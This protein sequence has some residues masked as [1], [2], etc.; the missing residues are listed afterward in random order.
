MSGGRERA[1][2]LADAFESVLGA[3][4]LDQG[5]EAARVFLLG[6]RKA[7]LVLSVRT[8]FAVIL[9]QGCRK[10]RSRMAMLISSTS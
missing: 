10:L 6:L 1:S 2:I 3:Y 8:A 5:M 4:Y 9:K 7:E